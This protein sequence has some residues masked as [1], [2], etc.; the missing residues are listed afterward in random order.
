MTRP[1]ARQRR[2]IA[3]IAVWTLPSAVCL[4]ATAIVYA[5]F[6]IT[7]PERL[8]AG[9]RSQVMASLRAVLDGRPAAKPT[10]TR[11]L[12]GPLAVTVWSHGASI[13]RVDAAGPD[14]GAATLAAATQLA[15]LPKLK[16]LSPADREA[17]RLQVDVVSGSAP[18]GEGSFV[19]DQLAIPGI[20]DMLAI[21]PGVEGVG[22]DF[23]GRSVLLLP[24]EIV[25][26]R[27]LGAKR[28]SEVMPDFAMGVDLAR[29]GQL[30]ASRAG[31]RKPDA[32][33]RFRTDTFVE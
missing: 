28:P 17:A 2:L 6:R 26:S 8:S 11:S 18:L 4:A 30:I 29:I 23:A 1:G 9:E 20:A 10:V 12:A 32:L 31:G 3:L 22:A 25:G 14:V 5:A 21:N 7:P 16:E 27:L 24:H 19:F 13:A 33:Y 15:A